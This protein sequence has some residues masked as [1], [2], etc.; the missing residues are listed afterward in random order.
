[1]VE[2]ELVYIPEEGDIFQQ[3]YS[4]PD[5]ATVANLLDVAAIDVKYPE[6]MQLKVGIF[7]HIVSREKNLQSG[8][9]VEIYRPLLIDP[10]EKRRLRVRFQ[11]N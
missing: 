8:D 6:T 2:V 1:M 5:G 3:R 7:S 9:R 4:M 11:Q 10:K